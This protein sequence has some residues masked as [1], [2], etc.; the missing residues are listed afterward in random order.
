VQ[1]L[2]IKQI[3]LYDINARKESAKQLFKSVYALDDPSAKRQL[4]VDNTTVDFGDI[5][6]VKG[7]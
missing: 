4:D 3:D 2:T 7:V 6:L 5:R 1:L